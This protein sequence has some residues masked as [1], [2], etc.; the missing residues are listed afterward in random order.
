MSTCTTNCFAQ[1]RTIPCAVD[2]VSISHAQ[3][4]LSAV[5]V[6]VIDNKQ[7]RRYSDPKARNG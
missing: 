3:A 7:D 6:W 1:L 5:I 4:V 2:A